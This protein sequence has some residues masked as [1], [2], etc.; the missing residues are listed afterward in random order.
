VSQSPDDE[1]RSPS[2][3]NSKYGKQGDLVAAFL[4]EVQTG[5]IDWAVVAAESRTDAAKAAVR[6]ISDVPWPASILGAVDNAG[7][8][9]FA[10][11]G[12]TRQDFEHPLD[13]GLVKSRV[14]SASQAIAA[15]GKLASEHQRAL[16]QPFA[17]AGV[18]AA[19]A[20]MATLDDGL[21]GT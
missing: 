4:D 19:A 13:F 15:G 18:R 20:A 6:A 9:A 3:Q 5:H 2:P 12:L 1:A 10:A 17:E 7:L 11:R 21:H 8:H 14:S 16:L